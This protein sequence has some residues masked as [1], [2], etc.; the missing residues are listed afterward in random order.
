IGAISAIAVL[1]RR[2][3]LE[4]ARDLVR[5][6]A[7]P[8]RVNLWIL[9]VVAAIPAAV[10]GLALDDWIETKLFHPIT[11][12]TTLLLGGIA[13]LALEKWAG[14]RPPDERGQ[15]LDEMSIRQAIGIGLFQCLALIPGTSRSGA[16]IAGGLLL[17][18]NR[19]AAAEFSFLVGLPVLYGAC[20][21]KL[22]GDSERFFGPLLVDFLIGCAVSFVTAYVVVGPFVRYLQ[23]HTFRPFGYYR[24]VAGLLLF[25]LVALDWL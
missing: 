18:M 12:A 22:V 15:G 25:G 10:V 17:G 23:R 7:G 6:S 19:V 16:T 14:N 21:L 2:R 8:G 1:Y 4:S 3:L 5:R 11:V 20:L 13:L 9:L 24:I